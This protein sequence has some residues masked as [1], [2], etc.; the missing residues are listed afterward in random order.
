M[1][2]TSLEVRDSTALSPEWDRWFDEEFTDL[3]NSDEDLVR[4]EFE[5]LIAANWEDTPPPPPP[6][7][8]PTPTPAADRSVVSP[9]WPPVAHLEGGHHTSETGGQRSPPGQ[10]RRL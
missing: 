1:D 6:S 3:V 8:P 2:M 9:T 5:A 7:A 4:A 10:R